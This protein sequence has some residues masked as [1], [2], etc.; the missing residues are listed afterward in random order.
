VRYS[1]SDAKKLIAAG[2]KKSDRSK[3]ARMTEEECAAARAGDPHAAVAPDPVD[4]DSVM[5]EVVPPKE[6][7]Y[8]RVDADVLHW[9]KNMGRGYQ[10]QINAVL[11]SYMLAKRERDYPRG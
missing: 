9:F 2:K 6:P 4:W 1:A 10:S 11:R 7:L 8:M 5:V 3:I